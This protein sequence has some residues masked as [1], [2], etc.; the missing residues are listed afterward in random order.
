VAKYLPTL[1]STLSDTTIAHNVTLVQ[2]YYCPA[3]RLFLHCVPKICPPFYFL[4]TLSKINIFLTIFG[5]VEM[6]F[7]DFPRKSGY[8]WQV[9]WAEF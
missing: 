4:I 1:Y 9:R 5:I 2:T 6:T 8:S 3:S 7:L